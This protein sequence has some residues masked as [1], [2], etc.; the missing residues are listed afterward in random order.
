MAQSAGLDD[1]VGPSDPAGM[2]G[3][4]GTN[5]ALH[6]EQALQLSLGR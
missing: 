3:Q 2:G 4:P 5:P 6:I 1:L